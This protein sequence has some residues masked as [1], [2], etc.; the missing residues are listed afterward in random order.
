MHSNTRP[1]QPPQPPP[2]HPRAAEIAAQA[3]AGGWYR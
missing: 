1:P 2:E 3:Q